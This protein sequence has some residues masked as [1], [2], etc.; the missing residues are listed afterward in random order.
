MEARINRT[1]ALGVQLVAMPMI[2]VEGP[3]FR[4]AITDFDG[5]LPAYRPLTWN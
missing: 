4:Y 2:D 1:D 3:A 5:P